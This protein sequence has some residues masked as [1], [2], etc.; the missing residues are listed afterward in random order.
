MKTHP[1]RSEL[2]HIL[3]IAARRRE[4]RLIVLPR[5]GCKGGLALRGATVE[6]SRKEIYFAR[7]KSCLRGCRTN[8][9]N[10][11]PSDAIHQGRVHS[12]RLESLMFCSLRQVA[13][14][15]GRHRRHKRP[16]ALYCFLQLFIVHNRSDPQRTRRLT[17]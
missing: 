7:V 9:V 10:V 12:Q 2:E 5:R 13:C 11:R 4:T 8:R 1:S 15:R 6:W 16:L 3:R 14:K 17:L